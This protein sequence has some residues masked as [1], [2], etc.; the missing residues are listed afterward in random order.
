MA[1]F[2]VPLAEAIVTS[3]IKKGVDKSGADKPVADGD[4]HG[5]K[6]DSLGAK[7]ISWSRKLSWLNSMLWGGA[8]LLALEHIWHGEVVFYPPFLTAMNNP[9]DTRTMLGEMGTVGVGMAVIV[10]GA[11]LVMALVAD[12]F[13]ERLK[14]REEV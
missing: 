9:E 8:I 5:A 2:T 3:V 6:S 4:A 14:L 7:K 10:T 1:C 11:W 12:K 13:P